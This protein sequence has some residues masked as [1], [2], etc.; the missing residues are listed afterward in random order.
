MPVTLKD[1]YWILGVPTGATPTQIRRAYLK[2]A[3]KYHPDLNPANRLAEEKFKELQEAYQVLSDPDRRKQYDDQNRPQV[4]PSQRQRSR[5]S[6]RAAARP[7]SPAKQGLGDFIQSIFG[8]RPAKKSSGAGPGDDKGKPQAQLVLSLEDANKGG[9]HKIAVLERRRCP[10]CRG[11]KE[12]DGRPCQACRAS[13]RLH[14]PVNIDVNIPPGAR[15]G[16]LIKVA[17]R[18]GTH[19]R[20]RGGELYVKIVVEPHP[21]FRID[22]DDLYF[23]APITPWEAALGAV[24]EIAGMN[25]RLEIQVPAGARGGK[26]IRLRGEGLN[27]RDGSRGDAYVRLNI[28]VPDHPGEQEK[29]LYRELSRVTKFNPRSA[30]D[31]ESG[32]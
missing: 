6:S 23:D 22:G 4:T 14:T 10:I 2:L 12:V 20:L 32:K 29:S 21:I 3:R 31:S 30:V 5:P 27:R 11:Q 26:R 7:R 28:V 18:D 19:G 15:N 25:G 13:G 24:I 9:V 17:G 1:Y 16:S 8:M